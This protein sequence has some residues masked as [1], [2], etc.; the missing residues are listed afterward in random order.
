MTQEERRAVYEQRIANIRY[1]NAT[2]EGAVGI[3]RAHIKALQLGCK[4]PAGYRTSSMGDPG[5]FCP[6][7]GYTR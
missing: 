6:D 1:L 3:E 2:H 4:H 7:C 5:Y